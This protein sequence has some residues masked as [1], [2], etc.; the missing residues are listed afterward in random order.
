MRLLVEQ[1]LR[2]ELAQFKS[3]G[4]YQALLQQKPSFTPL[5]PGQG[6]WA[7]S[8]KP[9]PELEDTAFGAESIVGFNRR[10]HGQ[11]WS[12]VPARVKTAI[13][14]EVALKLSQRAES[15]VGDSF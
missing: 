15:L 12:E 4:L 5:T 8:T 9:S 11:H 2:K 1:I 6:E 14:S 3:S 13:A 10:K 7:I